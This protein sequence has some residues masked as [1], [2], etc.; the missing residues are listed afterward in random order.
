MREARRKTEQIEADIQATE[1]ALAPV[2]QQFSALIQEQV[3]AFDKQLGALAERLKQVR[4]LVNIH[5]EK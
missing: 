2:R 4:R 3:S 1:N 5:A